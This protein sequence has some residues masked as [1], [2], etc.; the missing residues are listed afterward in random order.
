MKK[1][2][3]LFL[4]ILILL[5]ACGKDKIDVKTKDTLIVAQGADART[6]DPQKAIDTPS[7][8]VYQQL[9]NLLVK[10]DENMEIVPDL[11][12]KWEIVDLKTTI[13]YLRK[14]IKFHNGEVLT[15]EDVKFTLDR[16]KEQPTVSFLIDEIE[17]VEVINENTVK[18]ITKRG[19]GPLLKHLSHPGAAIL[20]EKAVL[21]YGDSYGQH[22]VGTGPYKFVEWQSGDRVTLKAFEN[23]YEGKSKIENV[24]IKAIPEGTNR[25]IALETGE[26]DIV[27]DI[28]P[29][30]ID[31]VKENEKFNFLM[32]ASLGNSYLGINTTKTPFNDVKVRQAMA[33]AINVKDIIEVAYKNTAVPANSAIGSKIPGYNKDAKQYEFDREKAKALLAEAGYPDGFK[34]SIWINDNIIRK[35]IATILQDQFKAVGIEA[36]IE[37]LEWGA[38]IDR[39]AR[40]EHDMFILGWVTVTGDGDYGLYPLFH[41]SAHGRPGN[42]AFYSNQK[43]DELLD[44]ARTSINQDE[45]AEA[46]KEVQKIVQEDVPIITMVYTNQNVGMQKYVMNFK[47]HPTGFFDLYNIEFAEI[48]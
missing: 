46:Y 4:L 20:N 33:Y 19:F 1:I 36:S 18:I 39:T 2:K 13:F 22:P 31:K 38:Y 6:L 47:L 40:G 37:T 14:G 28:E 21:E 41:T 10:K 11:A 12:E 5:T 34:T 15:A 35:D 17:K 16:M 45:R 7:V 26:A 8:R 43:V 9:Y 23:Y 3:Y 27:Y 24:I 30:D 29:I 48:K 25:T 44:I 42:R 32:E